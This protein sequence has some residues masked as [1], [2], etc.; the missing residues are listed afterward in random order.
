MTTYK[1][2]AV[3]AGL[4]PDYSRAG[5]VLARTGCYTTTSDDDELESGDTLQMVPVPKNAQILDIHVTAK[6]IG[7]TLAW[8]GASGC[9]IGD[10]ASPSRF[11]DDASLD[12]LVMQTM[13]NDGKPAAIGYTYD[14][15]NDTIDI[16]INSAATATPTGTSIMMTVY[17]KMAGS[18]KDEDFQVENAVGG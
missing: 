17:Y 8:T 15:G 12:V 16:F 6:L 5:V 1:S 11:M 14:E 10:G 9:H 18:I 2:D 13:A 7:G 3:I 4:M